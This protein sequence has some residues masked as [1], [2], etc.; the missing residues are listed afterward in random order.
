MRRIFAVGILALGL[1]AGGGFLFSQ[2]GSHRAAGP[3]VAL[4]GAASAQSAAAAEIVVEDMV[5][6]NPDAKVEVIEYASYTCP[7][8]ASFH[9]GAYKNLKQDYI[10]TGLI[11][12]V[13]REV[14]FDKYGMWA[15]MIA[16]CEPEK[17]FGITDLI[18]AEQ[19]QWSRAGSDAAIA[20]A[21]RKIGLRAGVDATQLESCLRDGDK[22][23]ALVGWYRD[24]ADR[25]GVRSTPSFVINGRLHSNMAYDEFRGL[26]DDQL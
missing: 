24:N 6:G 15:S 3:E 13:Y 8:C 1:I 2:G 18:Y 25:D 20:D 4:P 16:R 14:Y 19:R 17:F 26:I 11:K 22:L 10:D 21:L 7:H 23:R 12:F 9:A 5:L